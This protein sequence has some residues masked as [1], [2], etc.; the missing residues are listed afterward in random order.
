M[1]AEMEELSRAY[2]RRDPGSGVLYEVLASHLETFLARGADDVTTPGLPRYVVR[3]LRAYLRCG[4]LAHGFARFLCFRCGADTFVAFS[5]KG[6]GFCPSC[7]GRRMA[8]SA[9]HLVDHVLPRVPVRQWVIS[10]PWALRYL[11]ARRPVLCRAVR[12]IFLRAVFGLYRRRAAAEGIAAGRTGAVNRIQRFGSS[13]NLNVHFHA[14]VLDGVY[15][16]ASPFAPPVFHDA[17]RID[18]ED[19]EQLVKTIRDRV[20][21]LLRRRGLL[22]DEGSMSAGQEYEHQGLLPLLQ[23]ASIQG[24]VAQGPDAG[25]HLGRLG[26]M[27]PCESRFVR[28]PS[29]AEVDG[30]SLHAAVR[31][32]GHDRTRL[33]HLCRYIARPPFAVGRLKWSRRGRL[34]YELRTPWRDGTTHVVFE[35]LVFIERLAAL[36][37]V[38]R[39]HLQTYH[40]VLA[41]GASWRDE[42]VVGGK[43][44]R[45][46]GGPDA[47]QK[48]DARSRPPHRYLWAELLRRVF[49]LDVLCCNRCHAKCR[50]VSLITSR[51]TIV[52]ILAHLG[53]ETDPP[54]IQPARAPPQLEF[55]F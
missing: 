5:C 26:R 23:A 39:M 14:L 28:G 21:R 11:L 27:G 24:R 7:G 9:A 43:Q 45:R 53:L 50:L 19:V 40:G 47:E 29:C 18:D 13:V 44:P 32:A 17:A 52:R 16:A 35:P 6:R 8:E 2:V 55:G 34:L 41:P 51:L 38:P 30:F 4:I 36:V 42:V 12:R 49:G 46:G 48:G 25:A 37:P 20:L 31:I 54:P 1:V 22:T 33:E 3:E 10:F 15:T